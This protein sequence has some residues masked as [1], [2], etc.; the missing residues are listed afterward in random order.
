MK[1]PNPKRVRSGPREAP[2]VQTVQTHTLPTIGVRLCREVANAAVLA[3]D[4]YE[5]RSSC[6]TAGVRRERSLVQGHETFG[7]RSTML[8]TISIFP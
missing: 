7:G 1:S 2:T 5:A 8:A 4:E 3:H 6:D